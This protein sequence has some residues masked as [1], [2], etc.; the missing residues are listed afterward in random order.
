MFNHKTTDELIYVYGFEILLKNSKNQMKGIQTLKNHVLDLINKGK[1][2]ESFKYLNENL[3]PE[4]WEEQ[5]ELILLM[6]RFRRLVKDKAAGLLKKKDVE[7]ERN[8]INNSLMKFVES[9]GE[10]DSEPKKHSK[11]KGNTKH[12]ERNLLQFI[13]LLLCLILIGIGYIIWLL[14]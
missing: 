5:S 7:N 8:R 10:P 11:P 2:E 3:P 4:L 6:S 1:I 13:V 9:L 14:Q 12:K